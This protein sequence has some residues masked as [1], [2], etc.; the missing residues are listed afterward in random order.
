MRIY[1]QDSSVTLYCGDSRDVLP[2]I[3]GVDLVL[4]DPPF[5]I[6]GGNGNRATVSR[7]EYGEDFD[8]SPE[9]I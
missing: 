5:G 1:Y 6:K 3:S 4:T 8:D 9:Y 2:G 7:S